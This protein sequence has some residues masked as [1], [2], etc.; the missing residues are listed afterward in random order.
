MQNVILGAKG[1]SNNPNEK[2]HPIIGQNVEISAN[3]KIFGNITIGDNVFLGPDLI[4]TENIDENTKIIKKM[5]TISQ[6]KIKEK[7]C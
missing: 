1:I 2:R 6:K 4:I 3:V 7:I 5:E